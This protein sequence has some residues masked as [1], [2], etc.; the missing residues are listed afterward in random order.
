MI[1]VKLEIWMWLGRELGKD[2]HALS[3]MRCMREEEVEDGI[4]VKDFIDSLAERYQPIQEKIFDRSRNCFYPNVIVNLNDR[5]ISSYEI[6]NRF[7]NH[8]DKITVLPLYM[9]G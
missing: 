6:S 9:G 7:L 1:R 8:G 2:F 5:V 3:E 4:T